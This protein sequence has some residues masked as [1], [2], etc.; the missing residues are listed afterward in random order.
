MLCHMSDR[1]GHRRALLVL[2][3]LCAPAA[4]PALAQSTER[5][6]PARVDGGPTT[7][8]CGFSEAVEVAVDRYPPDLT[9]INAL[10]RILA[11]AVLERNFEFWVADV[12]KAAA[13][14]EEGRRFI[15]Y[16][17]G[18]AIDVASS[19]P[20]YWP[21][22]F[23][24]AHEVAHHLNNHPLQRRDS[25]EAELAADRWAGFLLRQ[26]GATRDDVKR[27][28]D[29]IGDR[30]DTD[31]H[32][33]TRRRWAAAQNG[34]MVAN[35]VIMGT[36]RRRRGQ[37]AAINPAAFRE[38]NLVS[39]PVYELVIDAEDETFLVTN[40]RDVL[41][42]QPNAS[43]ALLAKLEPQENGE[44]E[45]QTPFGRYRVDPSGRVFGFRLAGQRYLAGRII[46]LTAP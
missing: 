3:F 42:Q 27:A 16:N 24:L 38:G 2:L 17:Q 7:W 44:W 21:I 10:N 22:Y 31:S 29:Q 43:T 26:M 36:P 11:A 1:L 23:V 14:V 25:H 45:V 32:P 41:L 19:D 40:Q 34:W 35:D 20:T 46:L 8:A 13:F 30:E 28:I 5:P 33:S 37:Q 18:Y 9:A 39:V 4:P 15:V 6:Q 12:P